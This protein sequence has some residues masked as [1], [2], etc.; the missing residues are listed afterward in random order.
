MDKR[1]VTIS[2]G[3]QAH[4]HGNRGNF[5]LPVVVPIL[6]YGLMPLSCIRLIPHHIAYFHDALPFPVSMAL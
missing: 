3:T 2:I 5:I 1:R 4:V 6:F